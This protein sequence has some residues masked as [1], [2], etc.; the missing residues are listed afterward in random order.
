MQN[1]WELFQVPTECQEYIGVNQQLK[2]V[3][4]SHLICKFM[5]S[6]D[7]PTVTDLSTK[8]QENDS[9]SESH[10]HA[11]SDSV[12]DSDSHADSDSDS[13]DCHS[14]RRTIGDA[15]MLQCGQLKGPEQAL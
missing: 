13:S 2:T 15:A 12:S 9:D 11:D 10:S 1:E 5:S 4:N 8:K 3:E 6:K 14:D 7:F